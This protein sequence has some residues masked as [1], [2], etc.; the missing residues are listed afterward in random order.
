MQP[1]AGVDLGECPGASSALIV[2]NGDTSFFRP[3]RGFFSCHAL[4][5]TICVVGW[6]LSLLRS[7]DS[8]SRRGRVLMLTM[9]YFVVPEE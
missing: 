2:V 8:R 7:F 3:F 6:N 5:P 9:L 1:G 4:F